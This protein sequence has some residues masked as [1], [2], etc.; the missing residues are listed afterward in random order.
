MDEKVCPALV[1][2][3]ENRECL[4]HWKVWCQGTGQVVQGCPWERPRATERWKDLMR[5]YA[6]KA[7]KA[8]AGTATFGV[9][10]QVR[11]FGWIKQITEL[12]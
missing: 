7:G 5:L 4:W 1:G 3:W 2:A 12:S 6:G 8:A 11:C 10:Y 9:T